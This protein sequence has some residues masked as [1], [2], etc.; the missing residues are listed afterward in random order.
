M[1]GV[2]PEHCYSGEQLRG[3]PAIRLVLF[4]ADGFGPPLANAVTETEPASVAQPQDGLGEPLVGLNSDQRRVQSL[5][6]RQTMLIRLAHR[7]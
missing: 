7:S 1:P 2:E 6:T 5:G 4:G 3:Q